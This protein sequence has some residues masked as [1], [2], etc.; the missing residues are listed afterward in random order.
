MLFCIIF[1]MELF[2]CK[3]F[4]SRDCMNS[5]VQRP[6][7]FRD[8]NAQQWTD[9]R[10]QQ[11][12][13]LRKSQQLKNVFPHIPEKQILLA[14][15]WERRGLRFQ[16]TPYLQSIVEKDVLGNPLLSDPVWRQFF[17]A[18]EELLSK[19]D[20]PRADEYSSK[21]E[22]WE[23]EEEMLTPI[24]HH[25][26]DNRVI[27]YTADVCLA[28]CQ[29]C[30]R[31]LQSNAQEEK[32]GGMR[33]YWQQTLEAIRRHPEIEEVIF[34]GGDPMVFDN[35]T[36]EKMLR[37]IRNINSIKAIRIHSRV[38]THNPFRIDKDLCLLLKKY[39]V[40][41]MAVHITHP[42]EITTDFLECITRIRESGAKTML[43][44]QIPLI[45]G[46]NDNAKTL[47]NLF[48][49]LYTNGIKPYYLLHNMPNTPAVSTQRTSV[50][51]GVEI[52]N[53]I[54]RRISHPALPEYIIV[55]RTGKR[56]VPVEP[57]GTS[58]FRYESNQDGQPVIRFKNWKGNWEEYLDA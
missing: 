47:W 57:E 38:F 29:Y 33:P 8:I 34:S 9:W 36:I 13:A 43:L 30:L 12:N 5:Y 39:N 15:E 24:A 56:A 58:E 45:K 28:Y 37:D 10:W 46:V 48:M 18:F 26:Y 52:M 51:R 6:W 21:K 53:Q 55:H 20:T 19:R 49:N 25:K 17:P 7:Y 44:A 2:F 41:E 16:V 50:K 22:N 23:I 4:K 14:L 40:T 11:Q 31:S 27:L 35:D 32:H 3:H 1:N 42:N 54:G